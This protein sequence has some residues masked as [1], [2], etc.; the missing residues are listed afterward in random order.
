[1]ALQVLLCIIA[2]GVKVILKYF[3]PGTVF[4]SGMKK[5]QVPPTYFEIWQCK[6]NQ[7]SIQFLREKPCLP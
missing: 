5:G 6:V 2:L 4:R 3:L 1:M 7:T